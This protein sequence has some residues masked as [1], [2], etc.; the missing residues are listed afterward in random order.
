MA[1]TS[2][3]VFLRAFKWF[4]A[5]VDKLQTEIPLNGGP[6]NLA[7]SADRHPPN[8]ARAAARQVRS[9]DRPERLCGHP[10][11][12][13]VARGRGDGHRRDARGAAHAR[14]SAGRHRCRRDRARRPE[15]GHPAD[16]PHYG[17]VPDKPPSAYSIAKLLLILSGDA[18]EPDN[19]PPARKLVLLLKNNPGLSDAQVAEPQMILGLAIIAVGTIL[20][21]SFAGAG[22]PVAAPPV[23]IALPPID[24]HKA[25][26]LARSDDASR[27]LELKLGLNT[28]AAETKLF[29]ELSSTLRTQAG[30]RR[31]VRA[32][33]FLGC[34]LSRAVQRAAARAAAGADPAARLQRQ[35]RYRP[36]VRAQEQREPDR[37]RVPGRHALLDRRAIRRHHAERQRAAGRVRPEG[38]QAGAEDRRRRAARRR[39]RRR[40]RGRADV[41]PDRRRRG[42]A[43][44]GRYRAEG[45]DPA[46]EDP[47][48]PGADPVPLLRSGQGR[49]PEP[50]RHRDRGV[51]PGRDRP[52]RRV[53]RSARHQAEP[54]QH[55][56]RRPATARGVGPEAAVGRGPRD[57]RRRRQGRRLPAL[58]RAARRVR[59][60]PRHQADADRRQ[61]DR[62][63]VD[64]EPRR[65]VAAADHHR[66]AAADPARLRLHDDRDR[67]PAGRAAHDRHAGAQLRALDRL[68]RQLPVPAEPDRQR[69]ADHQPAAH[70]LPV[71][72]RRIRDRADARAR[73]GHAE[74]GDRTPGR[75]DRDEPDRRSSAR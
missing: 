24:Q 21:R 37:A 39:D 46:R 27:K 53:D 20:D 38:Q 7:A 3:K 51:V 19:K 47:E 8:E 13:A 68:A 56:R 48:Q 33:V 6:V 12:S 58:R 43:A 45:D 29:A 74:P 1:G 16:R 55:A 71:Q 15:Q 30:G 62:P 25:F 49:Q 67:R 14:R 11:R 52:V 60:H 28:I 75:A 41:R 44:E 40:D 42:P 72:P 31:R 26:T 70:D 73:L 2:D 63:A 54:R 5:A 17:A 57:R 23:A 32:A 61:G 59:R 36:R 64:Q 9:H 22:L 66:A 50:D 35:H 69:A 10:R 34:G 65:L 18:D 4:K